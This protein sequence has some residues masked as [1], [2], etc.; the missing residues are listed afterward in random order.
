MTE[1]PFFKKLDR[2]GVSGRR[3]KLDL[4]CLIMEKSMEGGGGRGGGAGGLAKGG[5]KGRTFLP[6]DSPKITLR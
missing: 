4:P 3:G 1:V 5:G 2:T 6:V